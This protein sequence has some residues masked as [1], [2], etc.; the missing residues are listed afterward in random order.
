MSATSALNIAVFASGNGSNLA[1]I[2]RAIA[3]GNL[4]RCRITVVL[5]NNSKAGALGI[6]R[7][8]GI[9]ALHCSAKQFSSEPDFDHALLQHLRAHDVNFIA[10]AGYMKKIG[11]PVITKFSNRIVNIHPALL[12]A[13]G[14]K[15]MYGIHV[16]EAVIASGAKESGA[17]V[18]MVDDEYDRGPIVLQRR[19]ALHHNESIAT[20]AARVLAVEHEL[21]PEALR[22]FAEGRVT[23]VDHKVIVA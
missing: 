23:V 11:A 8:Y 9:P 21:Y 4:P 10:L 19:I 6:A 7:E 2:A 14:G 16:H 17:T 20:L 22:L 5:S 1:A 18:H 3:T 15:G 13:F 12:P